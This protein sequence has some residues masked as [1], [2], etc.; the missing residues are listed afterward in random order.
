MLKTQDHLAA[1]SISTKTCLVAD[2]HPAVTHVV[3]QLLLDRG[4]EVLATVEDGADALDEIVRLRP[5]I[6]VLDLAMPNL[7]GIEVARQAA[8]SSPETAV[9]LYTGHG[10][11]A[12]LREALDAGVQGLVL[13]HA[14]VI[15]VIRAIETVATGRVY[16]DPTLA[17]PLIEAGKKPSRN[18]LTQ[19]EREVLRLIA[20]GRS[21]EE[22]GK[23]LY[24]SPQTVRTYVRKAMAKLQCRNR[25]HAVATA[26]RRS[27][28]V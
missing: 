12:L 7:S 6:A 4:F 21:N 25:T 17:V 14:P 19:R 5:D 3:S 26:L 10:Q 28:I 27:L 16:V 24:I 22:I 1:P 9:L 11:E 8:V 2:D 15:E 23:A 20:D 13:K 18:D